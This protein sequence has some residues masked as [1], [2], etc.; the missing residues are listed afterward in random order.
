M[1]DQDFT[2]LWMDL[3]TTGLKPLDN[4]IL[5]VA[6]IATRRNLDNRLFTENQVVEL[7]DPHTTIGI[8]NSYVH[9]MHTQ[10]GLIADLTDPNYERTCLAMIEDRIVQGLIDLGAEQAENERDRTIILAGSSVKFDKAFVE[11]H[12]PVLATYLHYRLADVS[13]LRTFYPR[14]FKPSGDS[15]HRALPDIL[16]SMEMLNQLDKLMLTHGIAGAI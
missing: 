1:S 5:E 10:S 15:A 8:M 6:A 2:F 7:N 16:N 14:L 13:N 4:K 9:K 3:E 12:M 11:V